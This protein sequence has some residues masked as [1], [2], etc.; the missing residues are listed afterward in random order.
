M[1]R[2]QVLVGISP[3]FAQTHTDFTDLMIPFPFLCQV[4]KEGRRIEERY[5]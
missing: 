4:R 2:L 5:I 3:K 1:D